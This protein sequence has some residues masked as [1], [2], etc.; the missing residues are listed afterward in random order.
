MK[1]KFDTK[2]IVITGLLL[3]IEVVFQTLGNYIQFPFMPANINLTLVTIVLAAVWCG[4]VSAMILGFFNGI[5]ALFSPSTIAIFMPINPAATVLVCLL[6][7]TIAGLVASLIYRAFNKINRI[8]GMTAGV[9]LA[10]IA[11]PVINTGL[12]SVGA[13]IWFRPFLESGVSNDC[14]NIGAFL[15]FG[16]IGLN[17]ILEL[18]TTVVVSPAAAAIVLTRRNQA[19]RA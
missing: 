12:F 6:K 19:E 10:S 17:F 5:M 2:T 7:C 15:I 14:P 8:A 18:V 13:L 9:I 1:Q 4:P 16:V 3:A 11:V